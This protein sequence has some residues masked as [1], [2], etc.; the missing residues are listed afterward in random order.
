MKRPQVGVFHPGTQHSWQTA[1]ALYKNDFLKWYVT[2][3][4]YDAKTWPYK[5]E[6]YLPGL[7]GKTLHNEFKRFHHPDLPVKYVHTAGAYEWAFRLSARSGFRSLASSLNHK[8]NLF[9]SNEVARRLRSDRVEVLW[10]YDGCSRDA[11]RQAK[12]LDIKRVLDKTIGDPRV[13]NEIISRVFEIYPDYFLT[14]DFKISERE[15]SIR[16]EEYDLADLIL[17]G[18]EFCAETIRRSRPDV[19]DKI[20]ILNYCFDDIFFPR[21]SAKP[22]TRKGPIRFLFV[23]QA[24]PRKGIHLLLEA[25][26]QIPST[27]A[28]LTIMGQIQIPKSTFSRFVDRVTV[29]P[30]VRREEVA[31]Y[32]AESDCLVF[33]SYFEGSAISV[34]EALAMG[35]GIIQSKNTGVEIDQTIGATLDDLTVQSLLAAMLGIIED[36]EKLTRWKAN[37]RP[38]AESYTFEKYSQNVRGVVSR[39][40]GYPE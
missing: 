29:V 14:K 25:I 31:K 10:G 20:S 34:Y 28:V 16:D 12:E 7:I 1:R 13:Y 18:S 11:F 33:P 15:I 8:S 19:K 30:T 40:S 21:L 17:A 9:L 27:E 26:Q 24:G 36:R 37:A 4:F 35:L 2:S 22:A 32:M 38:F 5:V 39:I 6:R 23:G 3:I